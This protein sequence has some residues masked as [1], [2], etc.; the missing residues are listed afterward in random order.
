MW[1]EVPFLVFHC[2]TLCIHKRRS[3]GRGGEGLGNGTAG[4]QLWKLCV[5]SDNMLM[6]WAMTLKRKTFNT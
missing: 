2:P 3:S 5:F 6:I 1:P 4:P